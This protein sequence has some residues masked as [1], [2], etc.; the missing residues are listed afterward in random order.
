MKEK[1]FCT[2]I[3]RLLKT[4]YAEQHISRNSVDALNSM[5]KVVAD[6]LV[7]NA[8]LLIR[9]GNKKTISPTELETSVRMTMPHYLAVFCIGNAEK[10]VSMYSSR[11]SSKDADESR[12]R[13]SHC[14]LVF[15]VSVSEKHLRKFGQ[16]NSNI[17]LNSPVYLAA[18]L[19]TFAEQ[20]LTL[21]SKIALENKKVTITNR[22]IFL[23]IMGNP[24]LSTYIRSL[25]I[26]LLDSGVEPQEIEKKSKPRL[27]KR[28]KTEAPRN[29]RWRPGT[30][31]MFDIRRLQRSADLLIQRAP[32]V[33][34]VKE[35]TTKSVESLA[36]GEKYRY[37]VEFFSTLQSLV[38][39][40]VIEALHETNRIA[41]HAGRETVYQRDFDLYCSLSNNT[42]EVL[43]TENGLPDATM[44]LLAL[45]GGIRR[46]GECLNNAIKNYVKYIVQK[47]MRSIL[48]CT[49]HHEVQTITSKLMLEALNMKGIYPA[50]APY[51]RHVAS[52]TS[53]ESSDPATTTE[54]SKHD[55]AE[56]EEPELSDVEEEEAETE[57]ETEPSSKVASSV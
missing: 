30:K 27:P 28:E 40:Q 19:Q 9:N 2:Y 38:E 22:H 50:I 41:I 8:L 25:G 6:Q 53:G 5:I 14:G 21:T 24:E 42:Y 36:I 3:I 10:A 4:I 43:E 15:S 54:D 37:S 35:I 13:E 11:D 7:N 17:T 29:H 1:T 57:D 16:N 39:T 55:E 32:F 45:R 26:V 20:I 44:R 34:L 47:Y 18:V 52:K 51:H 49:K 56:M 48:L 31:T 46:T 33:R 23:A 12:S